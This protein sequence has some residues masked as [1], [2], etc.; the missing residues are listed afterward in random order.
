MA[1]DYTRY[2][3]LTE[4]QYEHWFTF[5]VVR[6]P[7]SRMVSFYKFRGFSPLVS[8]PTFVKHYL[9]KYFKDEFWFF[10]NQADFIYDNNDRLIVD[11]LGKMERLDDDFSI[12]ANKLDIPFT[13]LPKS[14]TSELKGFF[15]KKS[16]NVILKHPDILFRLKLNSELKRDYRELYT[17]EALAIV[18]DLY[19]RDIELLGYSY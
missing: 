2:G 5:S 10:R 1:E 18:N 6:N 14:N 4:E 7:W 3:Y 15:S 9:P 19:A 11:F 8:F 12:I 16:A 17:P 13:R